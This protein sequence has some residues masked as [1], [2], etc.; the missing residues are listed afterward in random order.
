MIKK[1]KKIVYVGHS[2]T[3]V[4][5]TLY[6][7]FQVWND[8]RN[9]ETRVRQGY[10]RVTYQGYNL[11]EFLVKVIYTKTSREAEL[12][13]QIFIEKFKPIDNVQKIMMFSETEQNTVIEDLEKGEVIES[14]DLPF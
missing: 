2:K 3:D 12:L 9:Y 5:K 13:E 4:K 10:D 8:V 14:D 7:H 11:N 6:R 1:G